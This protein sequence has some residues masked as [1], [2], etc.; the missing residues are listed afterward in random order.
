LGFSLDSDSRLLSVQANFT[1]RDAQS[2]TLTYH[3]ADVSNPLN[4]LGNV[5]TTAPV[6]INL[7]QGRI[8]MPLDLGGQPLRLDIEGRYQ[9]D[10]PRPDRGSLASIE[11]ALTAGL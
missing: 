2:F 4:T 5:V 6:V 9:D 10:R 7:I 8:S 11:I 1:D 3:H